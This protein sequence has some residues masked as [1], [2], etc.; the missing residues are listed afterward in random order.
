[1][2]FVIRL[3]LPWTFDEIFYVCSKIS[4]VHEYGTAM[5]PPKTQAFVPHTFV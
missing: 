3:I 2:I 1:M 5:I 4:W